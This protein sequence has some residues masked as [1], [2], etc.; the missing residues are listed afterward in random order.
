MENI[1]FLTV[2]IFT[3]DGVSTVSSRNAIFISIASVQSTMCTNNWL[4]HN[5]K[6]ACVCLL[7]IIIM[8]TYLK[9]MGKQN[10]DQVYSVECVVWS[11]LSTI[12]YLVYRSAYFQF[13]SLPFSD[14]VNSCTSTCPI[15][16]TT[17]TTT[18]TIIIII[19]SS[20]SS[21]ISSSSIIISTSIIIIIIIII[22][23]L[24]LGLGH[25]TMVHMYMLY[26]LQRS[27]QKQI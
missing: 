5:P 6:V 26:V 14:W 25:E 8:Q 22:V 21:S 20:S 18:T 17:T 12:F 13:I 27:Y 19:S 4:H 9:A 11:I 7:I 2:I 3:R 10:A 1:T 23:S 24:C 15:T 16:T